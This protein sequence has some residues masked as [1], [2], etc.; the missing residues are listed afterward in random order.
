MWVRMLLSPFT[1]TLL[2]PPPPGSYGNLTPLLLSFW[3]CG[4]SVIC[5]GSLTVGVVTKPFAFEGRKR[6]SQASPCDT[7]GTKHGKK[8]HQFPV[9][10][11]GRG[12]GEGG[13][14]VRVQEVYLCTAWS[15]I[16]REPCVLDSECGNSSGYHVFQGVIVLKLKSVPTENKHTRKLTCF[17]GE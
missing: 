15:I 16:R 10:F 8:L 7:W 5:Q 11:R 6:M 17:R 1:V 14:G 4:D 3:C 12:G 13:G 9:C 2:S